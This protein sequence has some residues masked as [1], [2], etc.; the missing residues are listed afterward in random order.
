[1]LYRPFYVQRSNNWISNIIGYLSNCVILHCFYKLR[2]ELF[3]LQAHLSSS[4][5]IKSAILF[6]NITLQ[7][8]QMTNSRRKEC[9]APKRRSTNVHS[10]VYYSKCTQ[11]LN[12][13]SD[14]VCQFHLS[15]LINVFNL[16]LFSQNTYSQFSS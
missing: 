2:F 16:E 13:I 7:D 5:L 4:F 8:F 14:F 1:M 10:I 15:V 6:D 11:F 3:S 12:L 9:G